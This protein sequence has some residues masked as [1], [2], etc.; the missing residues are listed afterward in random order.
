MKQ[1]YFIIAVLASA[2]IGISGCRC[3][4]NVAQPPLRMVH[5]VNFSQREVNS[6]LVKL[7]NPNTNFVSANYVFTATS[8]GSDSSYYINIYG[9]GPSNPDYD[10][11]TSAPDVLIYLPV[12]S[13]TYQVS[14][15]T[16]KS[17][18]CQ[19]CGVYESHTNF[20][21]TYEING[22]QYATSSACEITIRK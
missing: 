18:V 20:I 5:F 10:Y 6:V 21:N 16:F 12:D 7:Y 4:C 2:V 22:T 15:I 9:L 3:G 8:T 19:K 13:L 17:T 11:N 1:L 14:D